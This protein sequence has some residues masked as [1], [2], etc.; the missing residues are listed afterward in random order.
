LPVI[1]PDNAAFL[2]MQQDDTHQQT[3][4][5]KPYMSRSCTDTAIKVTCLSRR[6]FNDRESNGEGDAAAS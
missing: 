3:A 4:K 6:V 5:K 1:E 2:A